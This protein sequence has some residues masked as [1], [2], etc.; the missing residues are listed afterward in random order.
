MCRCWES[1]R[2]LTTGPEASKP[3]RRALSSWPPSWSCTPGPRR[4]GSGYVNFLMDE[5]QDR[6]R[7]SYRGNYDRLAQV[8]HRYD[9]DNV[10]HVNQNIHPGDEPS[11]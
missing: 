6:V 11:P 9:P 10:F 7:A 5:G 4:P 2:S 1:R 8:K 3:G